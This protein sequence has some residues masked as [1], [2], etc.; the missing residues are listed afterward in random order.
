MTQNKAP[1]VI[2]KLMA[3]QVNSILRG[4][5]EGYDVELNQTGSQLQTV[6]GFSA[7]ISNVCNCGTK[8]I[9]L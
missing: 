3:P 7:I 9:L 1:K 6:C 8:F 5:S 2:K 4:L